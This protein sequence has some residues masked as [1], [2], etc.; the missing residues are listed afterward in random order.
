[1][2]LGGWKSEAMVFRYVHTNT[3]HLADAIN[4]L[5]WEKSVNSAGIPADVRD[6]SAG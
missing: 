4:R 2:E 6:G 3:D 1:M 5:P